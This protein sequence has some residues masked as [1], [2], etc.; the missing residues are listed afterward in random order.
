VNENKNIVNL[1][2]DLV[3]IPS[4]AGID[5]PEPILNF[6]S[7]WLTQRQVQVKRL[8]DSSGDPVG[9]YIHL[10][11]REPGPAICL[12]ACL[13]TAPFGDEDSWRHPP[14]S[15]VIEAGRLNGRG[16]A[17]SKTAAAIFSHLAVAFQSE[18]LT[19]GDLYILFD[20]D[21]HTGDFRGIKQFLKVMSRPADAVLIGY[22]GNEKLVVGSR[23]FLRAKIEVYGVA[24]HSGSSSTIGLNAILKMAQLI[25][26]FN[27]EPLPA[28][29]DP[30][31]GVGPRVSVTEISGG[32][33]FSL[34]P[35][36]SRCKV[37]FRLTPG[38]DEEVARRWIQSVVEK[39]DRTYPSPRPTGIEWK[40]SWPAYRVSEGSPLVKEFLET[41]E[42]VFQRRIPAVVSGPSNIGNYLAAQDI[43][44]LAG[45]GV[46]YSNI[47]ATDESVEIETIDQV[48]RVYY[49]AVRKLLN[50]N[51]ERRATMSALSGAAAGTH[52]DPKGLRT[53][54]TTENEIQS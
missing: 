13:D 6:L 40:E 38:V 21:E 28:E 19:R 5:S 49:G 43:P 36:L 24:A 9:L 17:D 51:L 1:A 30:E 33:G 48:Y 46:S 22:P 4:R 27:G 50:A 25:E 37:D 44:A 2:A 39:I 14:C 16:S 11:A 15:G 47:H 53:N 41:A 10:E 54:P 35:D 3:R 45:F 20:S 52:S 26:A 34:V 23:G 8:H 32:E 7:D 42:E 12:N 31:F 18:N 29:D